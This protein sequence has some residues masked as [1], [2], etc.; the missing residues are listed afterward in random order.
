MGTNLAD[1]DRAKSG[2]NRR[3]G[4][5]N[6]VG[7]AGRMGDDG[8]PRASV[9]I[10][11]PRLGPYYKARSSAAFHELAAAGIKVVVLETASLDDT[12]AWEKD[13]G[14]TPFER[15]VALP[16]KVYERISIRECWYGIRDLL[17]RIDPAV[18]FIHGY[19]TYDTWCALA[20]CK[21]HKRPAIL[22][23]DS[24]YDDM[25][26]VWWKEWLKGKVVGQFKAALI[27]G[28]L[29]RIYMEEL[30]MR[31]ERIFDGF[32]A[33]DNDFFWEGAKRARRNPVNYRSLAGL[34]SAGPFFLASGRFIK[35]KNLDGLLRAYAQYR[36]IMTAT[37]ER[38]PPWRLVILGD[39][40]ERRALEHLV[41]SEGIQ[42][43]SF[44]GF[45][46]IGE[47]PIYYGLARVFV[48]PAFKDTWGLVVN[49]AMAA[50]LP[51]LVSKRCGC[52]PDLVSEGANGYTF[53]PDDL[54]TMTD[55]MVRVSSGHVDLQSMS[56]ASRN[57][58]KEWG[59]KRFVQGLI[60][61]LQVA[62]Q[63]ERVVLKFR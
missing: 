37:F 3:A 55:L 58:I 42:G 16:G 2:V 57:L 14:P 26:R 43:V 63:E 62:L 10:Q 47:L 33:V 30:G 11:W 23:S 21:L 22:M 38:I 59:L 41:H 61:A 15:F 7:G 24:K 12:Y 36:R 17:E 35:L 4:I 52:A 13:D 53:A 18:V 20:W 54:S 19:C 8:T 44:P 5:L 6:P 39:G 50:G 25:K 29:Q 28:S 31:P 32:D 49:E 27:A 34:E 46:Q 60:G 40:A 45:L 56:I 1:F 48:H 51:V 9:V